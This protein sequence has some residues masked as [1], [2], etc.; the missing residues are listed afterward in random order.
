MTWEIEVEKS[1]IIAVRIR[2]N[3]KELK[4]SGQTKN[5]QNK[6]LE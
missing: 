5:K 4:K 3:T 2:G 1:Q 6:N